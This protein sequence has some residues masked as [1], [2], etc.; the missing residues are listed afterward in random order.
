[1]PFHRQGRDPQPAGNLE[2]GMGSN[3]GSSP[4]HGRVEV[5]R[6]TLPAPAGHIDFGNPAQFGGMVEV[7]P[8]SSGRRFRN[9]NV[10]ADCFL[11]GE[12]LTDAM[13]KM[14]LFLHA[15]D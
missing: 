1:M 8:S 13:Q 15:T 14:L 4:D 6:Q 10:G 12:N 2:E 3:P 5:G 7:R 9:G 11:P